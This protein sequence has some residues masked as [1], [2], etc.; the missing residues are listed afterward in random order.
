MIYPVL[1]FDYLRHGH[2]ATNVWHAQ[3]AGHPKILT[4]NGPDMG[5]ANR[6]ASMRIEHDDGRTEAIP[7]IL[8]RDEYPFACTVE[9]GRSAWVGHIPPEQNSAQGGLIAAFLRS[10][11]VFPD[12]GPRSRFVAAVTNYPDG[13]VTNPCKPACKPLCSEGDCRLVSGT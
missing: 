10:K 11:H 8:S 1:E 2:L 13:P 9:G 7:R 6:R 12:N 4:Y 3:M 5:R